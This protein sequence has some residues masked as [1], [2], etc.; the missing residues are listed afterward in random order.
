MMNFLNRII[1][2]ARPTFIICANIFFIGSAVADQNCPAAKYI[3]AEETLISARHTLYALYQHFQI[4]GA[5]DDGGLAEGYSD[6]V[7]QILGQKWGQFENFPATSKSNPEFRLWIL[8]NIN[9]S[10]SAQDL[11]KIIV[12]SDKCIIDRVET[13]CGQIRMAAEKLFRS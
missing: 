10:V 11:K 6:A 5:C 12:N 13:L 2:L 7:V 1:L 4:L 9:S 8:K 3:Q